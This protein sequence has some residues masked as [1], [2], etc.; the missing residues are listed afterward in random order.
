MGEIRGQA[1]G[2]VRVRAG[3]R[4][5][6]AGDGAR[7]QGRVGVLNW[8]SGGGHA[9]EVGREVCNPLRSRSAPA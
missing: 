1:G 2:D 7:G 5:G 8:A 4:G 3:Q 6:Q 9:G